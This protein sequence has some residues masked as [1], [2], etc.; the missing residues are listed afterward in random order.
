MASFF[1]ELSDHPSYVKK[2]MKLVAFIFEFEHPRIP[3]LKIRH[4]TN[5]MLRGVSQDTVV[6]RHSPT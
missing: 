5:V 1:R 4:Q 6:T 3:L 2:V